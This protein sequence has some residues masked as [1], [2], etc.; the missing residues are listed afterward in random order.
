MGVRKRIRKV[1][2]RKEPTQDFMKYWRVVKMWVKSKYDIGTGDLELLFYLY[3]EHIFTRKQFKEF[4]FTLPW[5]KQRF[6][7][8]K[9]NGWINTWRKP[10]NRQKGLY[11]VS[12]KGKRLVSSVY[13]KL[14]GKERISQFKAHNP[15]YLQSATYSQNRM[16]P[17]IEKFNKEQKE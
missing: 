3:S 13:R 2:D 11:E 17:V 12:F 14:L 7:R 15:I 6:A 9:K 4:A 10:L 5:D 16:K 1:Y 8:L